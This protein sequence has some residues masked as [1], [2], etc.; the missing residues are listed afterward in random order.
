MNKITVIGSGNVGA[1][2]AYTLTIMGIGSEIV[3]IDL[4]EQKSLGEALDIKH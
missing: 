3:M 2:I 1:T 4:N